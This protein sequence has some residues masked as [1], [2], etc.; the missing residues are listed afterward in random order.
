MP[1]AEGLESRLHH[2][3][4]I[5]IVYSGGQKI[6]MVYGDAIN[7]AGWKTVDAP[8]TITVT[9]AKTANGSAWPYRY[10]VQSPTLVGGGMWVIQADRVEIRAGGGD[11]TVILNNVDNGAVYLGFGNDTAKIYSS[12]GVGVYALSQGDWES[13]PNGSDGKDTVIVQDSDGVN[14]DGGA[15]GDEFRVNNVVNSQVYGSAGNDVLILSGSFENSIFHGNAGDDTVTTA[16]GPHPKLN[17]STFYGDE[18]NDTINLQ[19]TMG[20]FITIVG[21]S[22]ADVLKGGNGQE[23]IWANDNVIGNG[24]IDWGGAADFIH[25]D[26]PGEFMIWVDPND[27]YIE[28]PVVV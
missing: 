18:D 7:A 13:N 24:T 17:N 8:D 20:L 1:I 3:V 16:D 22:G 4:D 10:T 21:G 2:D 25:Y 19:G 14:V 9:G 11:D 12:R 27:I 28:H 23:T 15:E 5:N 26:S 6:L